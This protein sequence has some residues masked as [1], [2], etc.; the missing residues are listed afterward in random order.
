VKILVTG[1][2]GFIG[3]AVV[4]KLS[5][6]GESVCAVDSFSDYYSRELKEKRAE[7]LRENYG[8]EVIKVELS[9]ENQ[10]QNLFRAINPEIVIHLAGQAGVRLPMAENYKYVRDNLVAFSNVATQSCLANVSSFLYAS[11]SSVYGNSPAS[12]LSEGLG[13]LQPISFYGGTK[14][15]NEIL[16][17]SLVISSK[18]KFRGLRFFTVYGPWGRPDMAYLKLIDSGINNKTFNL[19]GDGSKKRDFTFVDD[20]VSSVIEL[21]HES[22]NRDSKFSD[23]VNIGGGRPVSMNA[24]IEII[25]NRLGAK[26]NVNYAENAIGDVA[27]TMSDTSYLKSLTSIREFV[28][29]EDGIART[30]EWALKMN[31][32]NAYQRWFD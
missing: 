6:Q 30:V 16:A 24:L 23:V 11:S 13:N 17:N 8:Q 4:Q 12:E 19:F 28:K 20:V 2:A 3:S 15:A 26:I 1:A 25:E 29:I 32:E 9:E 27:N 5:Q 21:F 31:A 22:E 18:T 10:V 7:N 14:L